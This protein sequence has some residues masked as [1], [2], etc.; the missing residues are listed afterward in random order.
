MEIFYQSL[1]VIIN[2]HATVTTITTKTLITFTTT[3]RAKAYL[4]WNDR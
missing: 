4:N 2:A 3:L 1:D